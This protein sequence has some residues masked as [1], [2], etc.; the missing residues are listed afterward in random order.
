MEINKYE[1]NVN[2]V[3]SRIGKK[4]ILFLQRPTENP[5][6]FNEEKD[7]LLAWSFME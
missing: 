7:I 4:T 3:H 1:T 2:H 5:A 6:V